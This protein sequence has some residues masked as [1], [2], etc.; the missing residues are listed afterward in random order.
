MKS[1]DDLPTSAD[2]RR[3]VV[4]D[5]DD[6]L[7]VVVGNALFS[8]VRVIVSSDDCCLIVYCFAVFPEF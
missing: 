6:N 8:R 1:M 3:W 2:M 5:D 4:D 7:K